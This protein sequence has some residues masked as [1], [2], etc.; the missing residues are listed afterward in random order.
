MRSKAA[1]STSGSM[2]LA[3]RLP[4]DRSPASRSACWGRYPRPPFV[5]N[6]LSRNGRGTP[7]KI[8]GNFGAIQSFFHE[9]KNLI[10]F[11]LAEVFIGHGNL[12]LEV[13]KL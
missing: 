10:S 13:K 8:V 3:L 5:S 2:R 7:A 1:L 4:T 6:N 12:T 9:A 11:D